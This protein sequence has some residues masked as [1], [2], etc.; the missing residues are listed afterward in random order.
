MLE[1]APDDNAEIVAFAARSNFTKILW[2]SVM[3]DGNHA[4]IELTRV[5]RRFGWGFYFDLFCTVAIGTNLRP[6]ISS[7]QAVLAVARAACTILA[8]ERCPIR[9][10]VTFVQNRLVGRSSVPARAGCSAD[11]FA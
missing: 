4:A 1:P 3:S 10:F 8:L 5:I 7:L 2:R 9:M 11:H 6:A